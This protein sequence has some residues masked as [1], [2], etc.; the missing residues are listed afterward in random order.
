[1]DKSLM[2]LFPVAF[3]GGFVGYKLKIPAGTLIFSFLAVAS[4]KVLLRYE[5][6]AL[7]AF[8]KYIPQTLVGLTLGAQC[9]RR[10]LEEISRMWGYMFICVLVLVV[11]GMII[12]IIFVKLN[13]LDL[14]TAYLSTSPGGIVAM[15]FLAA[16][17]GVNAPL[18]AI[19]HLFR[20][21][22]ILFTGPFILK[23]LEYL[24]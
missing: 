1:M 7:P 23:G 17:Q 12:A 11:V 2:V 16:D 9:S 10:V 19:F 21:L 4:V 15:I 13:V 22:F 5:G 18:V 8:L 3:L 14:P 6:E 24:R 20:I